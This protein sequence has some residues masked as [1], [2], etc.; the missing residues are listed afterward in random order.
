MAKQI[1]YGEHARQAILSGVNQ[2]ADAVKVTLGPWL[3]GR[4]DRPIDWYRA[5]VSYVLGQA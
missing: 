3:L 5:G 2:L 1:V 4:F